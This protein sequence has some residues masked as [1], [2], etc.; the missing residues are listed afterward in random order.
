MSILLR[1]LR[2][3]STVTAAGLVTYGVLFVAV[4]SGSEGGPRA[5]AMVIVREEPKVALARPK[6]PRQDLQGILVPRNE[7]EEDRDAFVVRKTE[8]ELGQRRACPLHMS[9]R[10]DGSPIYMSCMAMADG[11][12]RFN[13]ASCATPLVLDFDD[14]PVDFTS[15]AIGAFAIGPFPKTEW[16][17]ART[18]WLA[19]DLDGSGCIEDQGELF[20]ADDG[21]DNGFTK[22]ARLDAND[23]GVLDE[24]D[25]AFRSLVLWF[26]RDQD[27]AC[28]PRE[29]VPLRDAGVLAIA[30]AW[31][32][33][34]TKA[35]ASGSFE[36]ERATLRF[37]DREGHEKRGRVVDV[38][39]SPARR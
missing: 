23:D 38:Y 39:L 2:A 14:A 4:G 28:T 29:L 21:A 30:L 20:G 15:E 32:R 1:A 22:L 6:A 25:P 27:R 26:D 24:R 34:E 31:S 18:P 17:S 12:K 3:I 33:P 19:L 8:C 36:G 35:S 37:L 5:P 16:V 9:P 10:A 11:T 13:P 7:E